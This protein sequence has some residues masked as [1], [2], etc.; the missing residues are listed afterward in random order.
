MADIHGQ[1]EAYIKMLELIDFSDGDELYVLGDVVDRGTDPIKILLDMSMRPN[2]YPIMGNHDYMAYRML[3]RLNVEI[4]EEN[5]G[6]HLTDFDMK[7]LMLWMGDGGDTTID[8]FKALS[9]DERESI[10]EY[11]EEFAP[12]EELTAGGKDFVLVHGGLP[13]FHPARPLEDYAP[14]QLL[15]ER[16]DYSVRYYDDKYVI[17]GHTPTK[18]I[19][20]EYAGKIYRANG[21]IAIDCGAGWDIALGCIRLDDM[22]EFYV[23]IK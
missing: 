5:F 21:H 4:T 19:G 14:T 13:D 16:P 7:S 3:S 12:Y 18:N 6:S 8:G 20:E 15:I 10:L 1:Y 23:P 22:R 17:N 11:L 2:V 9:S